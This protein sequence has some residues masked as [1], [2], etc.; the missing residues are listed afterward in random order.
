M[1]E[2]HIHLKEGDFMFNKFLDYLK[3]E[4]KLSSNTIVN[5]EIDLKEFHEFLNDKSLKEV[6]VSFL[7]KYLSELS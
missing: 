4:R 7:R 1:K 6:D 5:Y 3:Y 2:I